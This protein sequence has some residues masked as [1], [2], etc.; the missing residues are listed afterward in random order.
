MRRRTVLVLLAALVGGCSGSPPPGPAHPGASPHDFDYQWTGTFTLEKNEGGHRLTSDV[1]VSATY[2]SRRATDR[3]TYHVG[4]PY[5]AKVLKISAALDGDDLPSDQIVKSLPERKDVFL[6]DAHLHSIKFKAVHRGQTISYRHVQRYTDPAYFPVLRVPNLDRVSKYQVVFNHPPGYRVDF[7]LFFSRDR[8][9][10]RV[11][12]TPTRTSI[13]F[14]NLRKFTRLSYYPFNRFNVHIWPRITAGGRAIAPVTAEAFARWYGGLFPRPAPP[15]PGPKWMSTVGV[16]PDKGTPLQKVTAIHD[17]VRR[18]VRYIADLRSIGGIVP[19]PA[20]V[21]LQ[22][23]FGDCKDKAY[24]VARLAA[25][26]GVKVDV[27]LVGVQPDP[28]GEGTRLGL[29]DHVIASFLDGDRRVFLD[30]TCRYCEL[31]NLPEGDVEKEAL[32]LDPA[33]PRR[34][35]I[36]AP[37]QAPSLEAHVTADVNDLA[38]GRAR[39]FLRNRLRHVMLELRRTKPPAQAMAALSRS[40][41]EQFYNLTLKD[42]KVVAQKQDQVELHATADLSGFVVRSPRRLYLQRVPFRVLRGDVLERKKDPHGIYLERRSHL[43]LKLTLKAPGYAASGQHEAHRLGSAD[44][45]QFSSELIPR[46]D[47]EV[48]ASYGF[49]Q[50]KKLL[51]E[52]KGRA[53]FLSFYEQYLNSRRQMFALKRQAPAAPQER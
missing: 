41:S 34:L 33:A 50:H 18:N 4:E 39:L 12:R 26:L 51:F 24:L 37:P 3:V 1:R 31:G 15:P 47:G 32:L 16:D 28:P 22:R 42:L 40:L 46:G 17:Y 19:R 52:G 29:F 8:F 45:A 5:Y 9:E 27:V 11:D 38:K 13:T 43:A 23:R 6:S 20:A 35:I 36:P 7:Q 30:P 49:R 48:M 14:S 44:L 21:V 2:L 10:P 53:E 25:A